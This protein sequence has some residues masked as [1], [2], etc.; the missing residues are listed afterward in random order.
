MKDGGI[1]LTDLHRQL[2]CHGLTG[3]L[4]VEAPMNRLTFVARI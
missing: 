4:I 2:L 1:A 3:P